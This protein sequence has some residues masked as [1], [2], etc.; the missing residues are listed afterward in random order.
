MNLTRLVSQ[1]VKIATGAGKE[2]MTIYRTPDFGVQYKS[3]DSPVTLA[4]QASNVF[5]IEKL[6]ALTPQIPII[7]EESTEIPFL[8]RQNYEY[9]WMI[10]PLDGTKEFINRNGDFAVNVALVYQNK[11]ILGVIY[12]PNTEGVYYAVKGKGSFKMEKGKKRKIACNAFHLHDLGLRIPVSRSYF[13]E[14]TKKL[15]AENYKEPVLLPR[16]SALKFMDVADG[17]ADIYPRIGRTMEWDTAAC[18]III[19]EAGGQLLEMTSRQPLQYNKP[20]LFNPD[21]IAMGKIKRIV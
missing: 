11:P 4:D 8:E 18:Q 3:D 7:S 20:S 12:V 14:D 2:I 15:I 10:D 17:S 6:T 5:L 21:F 16:G 1:V 19:E 9:F 13:N